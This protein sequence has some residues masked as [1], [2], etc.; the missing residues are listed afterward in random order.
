MVTMSWLYCTDDLL[1]AEALV[2]DSTDSV[3]F[4]LANRVTFRSVT[5]KSSC[6]QY[7]SVYIAVAY[8]QASSA[9]LMLH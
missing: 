6:M 2:M 3:R 9:W 8:F 1:H 5:L 7:A 4:C